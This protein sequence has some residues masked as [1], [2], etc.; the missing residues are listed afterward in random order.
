MFGW[1]G[2]GFGWGGNGM[3]AFAG[4]LATQNDVQRGFDTAAL[5]DQSR[6]ILSAVNAGTA[7]SVAATNQ[8]YHDI[9]NNLGDK[10]N[11]LARDVANV[12]Y[13]VYPLPLYSCPSCNRG[14]IAWN[15]DFRANYCPTCGQPINWK[16]FPPV[17]CKEFPSYN[18]PYDWRRI[19]NFIHDHDGS[20]D[21]LIS[22]Y[23]INPFTG[24]MSETAKRANERM[25]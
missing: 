10:Y 12:N 1:G 23:G 19:D 7:Q 21:K 24:E 22:M 8:V 11:E 15:R 13:N 16:G 9:V 18:G 25:Y 4:N 14:G 17:I 5:Q 2:N 20:Q 6:Y 3:G